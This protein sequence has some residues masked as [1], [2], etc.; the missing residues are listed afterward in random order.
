MMSLYNKEISLY[1]QA[2]SLDDMFIS[3]IYLGD[4]YEILGHDEYYLLLVLQGPNLGSVESY[5]FWK[6]R[7]FDALQ[8]QDFYAI[9]N[10]LKD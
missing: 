7:W 6:K 4:T 3:T 9:K 2:I 5:G 8:P 1:N 10:C